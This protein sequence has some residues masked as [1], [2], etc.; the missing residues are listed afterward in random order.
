[1]LPL[2][3]VE[4]G[5]LLPLPPGSASVWYLSSL[6]FWAAQLGWMVVS[7]R[8]AI[9]LVFFLCDITN[10][11]L[12]CVWTAMQDRSFVDYIFRGSIMPFKGGTMIPGGGGSVTC[13]PRAAC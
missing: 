2:S 4:W 11:H 9:A 3:S 12:H 5:E 7:Q 6:T 8:V 13:L 1:M 10:T